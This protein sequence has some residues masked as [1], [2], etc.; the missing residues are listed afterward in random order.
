MEQQEDEEEQDDDPHPGGRGAFRGQGSRAGMQ[1]DLKG[2]MDTLR[3][4]RKLA[5]ISMRFQAAAT[6]LAGPLGARLAGQHTL[7]LKITGTETSP[8]DNPG[9]RKGQCARI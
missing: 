6:T 5:S 1:G 7:C 4:P 9:V 3:H 8:P 2:A